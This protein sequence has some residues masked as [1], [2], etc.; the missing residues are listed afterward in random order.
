MNL[1]K[2]PVALAVGLFALFA[3]SCVDVANPEGWAAPVF[4]DGTLYY[5]SDKDQLDAVAFTTDGSAALLWTFPGQQ[6]D[7]EEE[8]DIE[9]VYGEPV[10][11]GDRIYFAGWEGAVYA[12]SADSGQLLWTTK[13]RLDITG[14]VVSGPTLSNGTLFI[15]T[16]EGR[17]YAVGTE[18]GTLAPGWPEDGLSLGKGIWAPPLIADGRLYIATMDGELHALSPETGAELWAQPFEAGSGAIP[19]LA[20]VNETTLWVP[21]LGKRVY[22]VDTETGAEVGTS[23]ETA[24]W[25][26]TRPALADGNAFFGDFGGIVHALDITTYAPLWETERDEKIKASPVLIGDTLV[27]ADR[28]PAVIFLDAETGEVRNTVPLPDAGTIRANLIERDGVAYVLTT[29]GQLFRADPERLTVVQV[30]I[31]GA[32]D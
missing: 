18:N 16:T 1:P 8:I 21:T 22:F 7:G 23:V 12:V 27:V 5:F 6:Q 10:V 2:L 20:L 32:P 14:G 28:S 19:D 11:D 15:G 3:A 30:P 13:G 31:A 9:A 17:V 24:D 26:W 4:E 29:R 25:V